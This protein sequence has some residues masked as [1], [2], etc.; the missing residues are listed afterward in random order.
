MI[1]KLWIN[2]IELDLYDDVSLKHTLQINDIAEIK[3]RQASF[4][5]SFN[6]PRTANNQRAFDGLGIASDT[7]VIPYEK[8]NCKLKLDGFD[9][10][11][12]GWLNVEETAENYKV[13]IYSG[14]INFFKAI[15][16]KSI[17]EL[18]LSEIEH[19]KDLNT[20]I[21]SFTNPNFRYLIADYNGLTHY[22]VSNEIINIDY[23]VPSVSVQ[24]LWDK[25]HS[26]FGYEYFGEIF[27]KEDFSN[28]WLT[29][30]KPIVID[31]FEEIIQG[32]G[33]LFVQYYA[34]SSD[35]NNY[36]RNQYRALKVNGFDDE[37]Y[38]IEESGNYVIDIAYQSTIG[39]LYPTNAII[40]CFISINEKTTDY[41][42][43]AGI[44]NLN[45]GQNKLGSS[46][47]I[48][49]LIAGD[50]L[51]F[52]NRLNVTFAENWNSV[53]TVNIKKIPDGSTSFTDELKDFSINDFMKEILNRFSLTVMTSDFNP[54]KLEYLTFKERVET[55]N[56][57]DWSDKYLERTSEK[58][59]YNSYA[60]RN[61]FTYQYNEK[62]QNFN[63]SSISINNLNLSEK[64]DAFASKTYSAEKDLAEF[65]I[66]SAGTKF[67][68]VFKI[69]DK[70]VKEENGVIEIEYKG[71]EKRYHFAKSEN[72][73]SNVKIGSKTFSEIQVEEITVTSFPIA[74]FSKLDWQNVLFDYYKEFGRVLNDSRIHIIQLDLN[75]MDFIDFDFNTL[76]YFAQEQQYYIPNKIE[77]DY[78]TQKA[79]GEF[80][81]FKKE[82][83]L[84]I[85]PEEIT[86]EII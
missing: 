54:L 79:S 51:S 2:D 3:D 55:A 23:L 34:Y 47:I 73:I 43:R 18:D 63:N 17:G 81:R 27:S 66:G 36:P 77:I 42:S 49:S 80:V 68:T 44:N 69:Y 35:P 57:L 53:Y 26:T 82:S 46:K 8:P 60:Q 21:S 9:F 83:D 74:N 24:Y 10:L 1:L 84:I 72:L 41:I 78:N 28:L 48:L 37:N 39:R 50:V 13:H 6:I 25:I 12:S 33:S 40:N 19:T 71:L 4:T 20:V 16:N 67:L 11:T 70:D 45:I 56:I 14:L 58:Y 22:G 62:E 85:T 29:Y 75:I 76:I 30:P 38:I 31:V 32:D 59:T 61:K 52:Y 86:P 15:E 5:N 64:T 65:Y 7:S